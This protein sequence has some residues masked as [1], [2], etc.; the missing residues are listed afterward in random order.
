[1]SGGFMGRR[2][3]QR[4]AISFPV[5]VRGFDSQEKPFTITTQTHDVSFTG[6]SLHGLNGVAHPGMKLEIESRDQKVWYRAQWVGEDGSSRS[7]QVGVRCLEQGKYIWGV[8]PKEWEPDTYDPSKPFDHQT[9]PVW[10]APTP[11]KGPEKRQFARHVCRIETQIAIGNDQVGQS[12]T[13]ADIS[14]GGCYVEMSPPLPLQTPIE[15]SFNVG[16]TPLRVSR[17]V[18]SSQPA[19]GLGVSFTGMS[20]DNFEALRRFAP[21][22][23]LPAPLSIVQP[24]MSGQ[25]APSGPHSEAQANSIS[26]PATEET[27]EAVVRL[28]LRKGLLTRSDLTEEM[29]KLKSV[30]R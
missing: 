26:L 1:M 17:E 7:G 4:I 23:T 8:A 28:L 12:G 25:R 19:M 10:S 6:T 29:E 16:E 20:P 3:E 5:I 14:H 27:L 11:W 13:L 24:R 15:L 2:S 21:P 22:V 18:R 9:P 30:R